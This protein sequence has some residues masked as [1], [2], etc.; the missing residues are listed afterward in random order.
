MAE[1]RSLG[2]GL[3]EGLLASR[4]IVNLGGIGLDAGRIQNGL[5][6]DA[7]ATFQDA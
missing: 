1:E 7:T 4:E 5:R 6:R 2:S 3:M